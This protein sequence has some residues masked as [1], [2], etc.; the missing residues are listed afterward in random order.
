MRREAVSGQ[1]RL[2]QLPRQG[3]RG[4]RRPHWCHGG[5]C[6]RSPRQPNP[7][8]VSYRDMPPVEA[9]LVAISPFCDKKPELPVCLQSEESETSRFLDVLE[10]KHTDSQVK[11][12]IAI[13]LSCYRKESR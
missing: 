12:A 2:H 5:D 1:G 8:L 13:S 4:Q 9:K 11:L 3:L 10:H 6:L 7:L